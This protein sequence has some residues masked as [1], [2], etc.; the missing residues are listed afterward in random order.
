MSDTVK[1]AVEERLEGG[2]P[3]RA[4]AFIAAVVIGFVAFLL[5][6]KLLRSGAGD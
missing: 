1:S 6:Y 3:G 2:K 4:K 5:A